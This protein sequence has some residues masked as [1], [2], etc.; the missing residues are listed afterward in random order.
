MNTFTATA[1]GTSMH[2][3]ILSNEENRHL[4]LGGVDMG[5]H[6]FYM[7]EIA[8]NGCD[9]DAI[10]HAV[11]RAV[12]QFD[13]QKNDIMGKI[14][15][16]MIYNQQIYDSSKFLELAYEYVCKSNRRI[17]FVSIAIVCAEPHISPWKEQIEQ[18]IANILHMEQANVCI[19]AET[20]EG[21]SECGR[22]YGISV[23]ACVTATV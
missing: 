14:S 19:V 12:Q 1:V 5:V 10:L 2:S 4:I 6:P 8:E 21:L 23:T 13:I 22:G 18:R 11:T 7:A 15:A 20:G 3:F 9:G 16:D 17:V